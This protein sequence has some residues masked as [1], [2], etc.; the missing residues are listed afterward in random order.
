MGKSNRP[1]SFELVVKPG[2]LASDMTYGFKPLWGQWD[3]VK[4]CYIDWGD[5]V[6]QDTAT[7]NQ[8]VSHTY[9]KAGTYKIKI[10]ADITNRVYL[11]SVGANLVYDCS[12]NFEKL[13]T[14]TSG[15]YMFTSCVNAVFSIEK[16]P[17]E[18]KDG[19]SMFSGCQ[20]AFLP[21]KKLSDVL[22]NGYYMFSGCKNA[23][24]P[25]TYLPENLGWGEGMFNGC[26][27]AQLPLTSLPYRL[28]SGKAMFYN[29]KNAEIN[30]DTLVANALEE[31]WTKLTNITNMFYGCSKVTGSR[32]AFLAKCPANVVGA[33]TAFNGTNTTE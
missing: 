6:T 18:V 31:G 30:L 19:D 10:K 15:S 13:G 8:I 26:T 5:G 14:M 1:Q 32:S 12:E 3:N 9:A 27:N 22:T 24:L 29:C 21:L 17:N 20:S 16:M 2:I 28:G 25:L 11:N 33:D 7:H 23:Q 4:P